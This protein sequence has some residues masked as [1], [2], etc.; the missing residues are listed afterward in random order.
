VHG[1][2]LN[3]GLP[4]SLLPD[5]PIHEYR[6]YSTMILFMNIGCD[7]VSADRGNRTQLVSSINGH[8]TAKEYSSMHGSAKIL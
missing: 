1:H 2:K 7:Y 8:T 4:V 5:D 3:V 6:H